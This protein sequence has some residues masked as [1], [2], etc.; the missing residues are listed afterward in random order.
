ME[1]VGLA[2]TMDVLMCLYVRLHGFQAHDLVM[3]AGGLGAI[4][5]LSGH[6][7]LSV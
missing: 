1:A 4:S 3:L 2:G 5:C 6:A 7:C